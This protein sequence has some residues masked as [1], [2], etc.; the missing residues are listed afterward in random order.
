MR[1]PGVLC[2]V[3]L[4]LATCD[5]FGSSSAAAASLQE[6]TSL[7]SIAAALD[8]SAA[9]RAAKAGSGPDAN[10]PS[11]L[12][13]PVF[14]HALP[15]GSFTLSA[16]TRIVTNG[17]A[18]LTAAVSY[19]RGIVGKSTGFTLPAANGRDD[20][21]HENFIV[22]DVD[23]SRQGALGQE[24]YTLVS[25]KLGVVIRAA[26]AHG[27][28]M[29]IQTLL[30]L[31]PN[32]VY[33]ASQQA[34]I[35]SAPG[36]VIADWPRYAYR[37]AMLDVS[38]RFFTVAQ[39]KHYI[40]EITLLK[41]NTLHL[42]LADDQ[43]W[44][45]AISALPSLTTIGASTQSGSTLS[46]FPTVP[47][48]PWY[49]TADDYRSIVRYAADRSI[50]VVPEIDGPSHV[51][52]AQASLANLNCSNTALQPYSGFDGPGLSLLCLTDPAHLANMRSYLGTVL[53][54]LAGMTAGP[55]VHVGGD[56]TPT[57]ITPAEYGDYVSAATGT[58]T[59][60]GKT[61]IG[62]HQI[63]SAKIPAGTLLEYWGD[64]TDRATIGTATQSADVQDA[65]SGIAQGAK[66]IFSPADHAYL[67]MKYSQL[68]PWGL[69]WEGY[70]SVQKSYSWDPTTE[71]SSTDGSINLLP[72]RQIAGLEAPLWS[73]RT[74][75]GST[76]LP[77]NNT[78][79]ATQ[80]VYADYMAFPRMASMAE[81]GWSKLS[82]HDWTAFQQRLITQGQRWD[83]F[84]VAFYRSP[85]IAWK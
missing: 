84:G 24:G 67:D 69:L 54:S 63:G 15:S 50:T 80:Q 8:D 35:W 1:H 25:G 68:T 18:D 74:Y 65:V 48:R 44:R 30:Q 45:I 32:A 73:D 2:A 81:I 36:V 56:E 76:A 41:I 85:E 57:G 66:F 59:A 17:S 4:L 13:V 20:V 23:A 5:P 49:Y 40:D 33:S 51:S 29:G 43:G 83:A 16:D 10:A 60:A 47:A 78:V 7:K 39:V 52:A 55:Y 61:P 71:L 31:L 64:D 6:T 82:S 77:D 3:A 11:L 12:P 53:S 72:A 62:W 38:R 42:H 34:G 26:T 27:M 21:R 19:L 58:V 79:W 22:L 14:E 46:S 70:T 28:Y 75:V 37:G 9:I